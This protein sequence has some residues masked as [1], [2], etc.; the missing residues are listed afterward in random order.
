MEGLKK[1]P[2]PNIAY[3]RITDGSDEWA[4]Q[5]NPTP[6]AKNSGQTCSSENILGKPVFSLPGAVYPSSG[7]Y[8]LKI[9]LPENAP[10]GTVVRYTTDGTEPTKRSN[11]FP[12]NGMQYRRQR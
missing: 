8:K 1:Q 12:A 6:D 10:E 4:Y 9:S 7:S 5:L 11:V 3:G 2:A